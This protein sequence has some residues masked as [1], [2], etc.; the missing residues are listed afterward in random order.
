MKREPDHHLQELLGQAQAAFAGGQAELAGSLAEQVLRADARQAEAW[1]L[2]GLVACESGQAQ[3]AL[4]LLQRAVALDTG[5][6]LYFNSLGIAAIEAGHPA[7]ALQALHQA[8]RLNP[9]EP[10][11]LANLAH[12]LQEQGKPAEALPYYRRALELEPGD[13]QIQLDY[14]LGLHLL[15]LSLQAEGKPDEALARL[16]E[17]VAAQPEQPVFRL[18]LASCLLRGG[19]SAPAGVQEAIGHLQQAL[20]LAPELEQAHYNLGWALA[21]QGRHREAVMA[22]QQALRLRPDFAEAWGNL[23]RSWLE[24]GQFQEALVAYSRAAEREPENAMFQLSLGKVLIQLGRY[25]D[26][27]LHCQ[28][29]LRLEPE[30]PEGHNQ[31]GLVLD[32]QGQLS[33]AIDHYRRAIDLDPGNLKA[34]NNLANAYQAQ[35]RPDLALSAFEQVV[36]LEPDSGFHSNLLLALIYHPELSAETIFARHR[37]WGERMLQKYPPATRHRNSPEPDRPLRIGYVSSVFRHHAA[38]FFFEPVLRGHDRSQFEIFCYSTLSRPDAVTRRLQ[39]SARHW[40]ELQLLDDWAAAALIQRDRID[41]L[42]DLD[43]HTDHNRLAIFA[44]KPAPIQVTYLGYPNTTGLSTVDYRLTDTRADP[45]GQNA[46]Y[47]SEQLLRLPQNFSCYGP[48]AESPAVAPLPALKR[49]YVCFGSFNNLAK[50]TPGVIALWAQ[51]LRA[52]PGSR[53]LLKSRPLDDAPTVQGLQARFA[54]EGIAASRLS[55]VGHAPGFAAH[56]AVYGQIDIALDPFPFNGATTTCEALWMGVPV[57]ALAGRC[58]AARVGVS[59]LTSIGRQD[60]IAA[61][62]EA[63]VGIAQRLAGDLGGLAGLRHRLREDMRVSCLCDTKGFT[64]SL[65]A[66]YRRIWQQWCQ[67]FG[68]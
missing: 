15:G 54:A 26:A 37:A 25:A 56:L 27:L 34:Y 65:E 63:Y 45:P 28:A 12:L 49:G 10:D 61:D 36:A 3:A 55:L 7:L 62:G 44:L 51:V 11:L 42:V 67:R 8:V 21:S 57:I 31:L 53:L 17:A 19:Y 23:G 48:P 43:G 66:A 40:R 46:E 33:A 35:G 20:I 9:D 16:R 68:G 59:M 39:A 22:Y 1:H 32:A 13:P 6:G 50:L 60:L 2:L 38:S 14:A 18:N 47:Y 41:I 24:L 4:P 52:V 30:H 58:H 5:Q 64:R 29:A